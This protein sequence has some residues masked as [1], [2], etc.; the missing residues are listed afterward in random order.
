MFTGQ[1]RNLE[2]KVPYGAQFI[3]DQHTMNYVLVFHLSEINKMFE[4][5]KELGRQLVILARGEQ[6]QGSAVVP[7]PPPPLST[8]E[9]AEAFEKELAEAELEQDSQIATGGLTPELAQVSQKTTTASKPAALKHPTPKTP[10]VADKRSRSI[11]LT[12]RPRYAD[13]VAQQDASGTDPGATEQQH[14]ESE[15]GQWHLLKPTEN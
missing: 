8:D 12:K 15:P 13:V 2:V 10:A 1:H 11:S 9:E 7:P 4:W 6:P 14:N 5:H 3:Q